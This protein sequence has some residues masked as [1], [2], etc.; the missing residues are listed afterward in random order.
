M[1]LVGEPELPGEVE[2]MPGARI[3]IQLRDL[4]VAHS[5]TVECPEPRSPRGP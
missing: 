5:F 4:G 1:L 2:D 3:V